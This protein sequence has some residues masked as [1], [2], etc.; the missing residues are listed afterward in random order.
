MLNVEQ[1]AA[2]T[3]ELMSFL[4]F[5]SVEDIQTETKQFKQNTFTIVTKLDKKA[6]HKCGRQHDSCSITLHWATRKIG[7]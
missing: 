4:E 2:I 3:N 6:T 5:N 1:G 7:L